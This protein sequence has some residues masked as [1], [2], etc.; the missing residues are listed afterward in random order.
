MDTASGRFALSCVSQTVA[1]ALSRTSRRMPI[2][3]SRRTLIRASWLA[4]LVVLANGCADRMPTATA[5]S[6]ASVPGFTS[7]PGTL[8]DLGAGELR[9][10]NPTGTLAVGTGTS[11]KGDSAIV[12][13]IALG[14]RIL[15]TLDGAGKTT[16][17]DRAHAVNDAGQIVGESS[18]RLGIQRAVLWSSATAQPVELGGLRPGGMWI[19]LDV[20]ASGMVV[21]GAEGTDGV[22]HAFAWT[23]A[24]G[25]VDLAPGVPATA[26][27]VNSEGTVVGAAQVGGQTRGFVWTQAG[28]MQVLGTLGGTLSEALD[29]NATGTV[30]GRARTASGAVHAFLW[31]AEG[32]M[33]DLGTLGGTRSVATGITDAGMVVGHSTTAAGQ[34]HAFAWM[35]RA[36]MRDL[37]GLGGHASAA[38]INRLGHVVGTAA[39]SAGAARMI[40]WQVQEVN[41]API[42][43]LTAQVG[44]AYE[45][46]RLAIPYSWSDAD[47]D[48]IRFYWSFGDGGVQVVN[49]TRA[50]PAITRVYRDQGVFT[51]QVI[52]NDPSIVRDTA[53]QTVTILNVAP[54]SNFAAPASVYEGSAFY[55]SV[56]NIFDGPAD[57]AAGLQFQYSC[58]AGVWGAWTTRLYQRNCGVQA[59]DDTL[60]VGV[61]IRDKD[62]AVTEYARQTIVRNY[63]PV[64]AAPTLNVPTLAVGATLTARGSFSDPGALDAPWTYDYSWGDGKI[65]RTTTNTRGAVPPATHVYAAPGSYNVTLFVRDKDGR[66]TR[67]AATVVTVTP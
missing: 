42:V 16:T 64:P 8:A 30:V 29:V 33:Q 11:A 4:G 58:G 43:A 45:G 44:P 57:L 10:V 19:A 63:P 21:G 25:M 49:P 34:T 12:W 2:Q 60:A 50:P 37:G 20:N 41:S 6:A 53:E 59:D 13:S 7:I 31:T 35:P 15:P 5:D 38:G 62:G 40:R 52:V 39:D 26:R 1:A 23:L 17:A 32:G 48:P 27:A 66:A 46:D 65:T 51:L 3:R 56:N 28:G 36:G 61:R 18:S 54:R 14:R 67:S 22:F 55:L 9:G 47:D 24:G